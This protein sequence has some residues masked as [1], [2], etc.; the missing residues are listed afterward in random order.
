M[1]SGVTIR[2]HKDRS[3]VLL[4]GNSERPSRFGKICVTQPSSFV[5]GGGPARAELAHPV[6]VQPLHIFWIVDIVVF[7]SLCR[8]RRRSSAPSGR[9]SR[10]DGDD[11]PSCIGVDDDAAAIF[12][13]IDS[14]VALLSQY[15]PWVAARAAIGSGPRKALEAWAPRVTNPTAKAETRRILRIFPV[16]SVPFLLPL[17]NCRAQF[18]T[19]TLQRELRRNGCNMN[20]QH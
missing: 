17:A 4:A 19:I 9:D 13:D 15:T 14:D 20:R 10:L 11:L 16:Y 6:L 2:V 7:L 8:G 12:V 1:G 5:I 18:G 3:D